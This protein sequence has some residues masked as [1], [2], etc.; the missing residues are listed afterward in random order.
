MRFIGIN[1][2]AKYLSKFYNLCFYLEFYQVRYL[3]C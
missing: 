1:I 2:N 3:I